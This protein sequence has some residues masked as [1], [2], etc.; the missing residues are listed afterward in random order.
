MTLKNAVTAVAIATTLL[1]GGSA[2]ASAADISYHFYD[3]VNVNIY[4]L[5]VVR[6]RPK[7]RPVYHHHGYVFGY[8]GEHDLSSD[9]L[10]D[11]YHPEVHHHHHDVKCF[12]THY[13][14]VCVD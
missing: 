10:H 6:P 14:H 1:A 2:T 3:D 8:N 7:A 13:N 11:R 12:T 9:D 4:N 5:N